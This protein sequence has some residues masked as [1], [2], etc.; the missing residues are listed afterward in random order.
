MEKKVYL[1]SSP[2]V[3]QLKVPVKPEISKGKPSTRKYRTF[4]TEKQCEECGC[5]FTAK[6]S[7][8]R[9]CSLR[10]TQ[11]NYYQRN[12]IKKKG[13][14]SVPQK[15]K[16]SIQHDPEI[17]T[18]KQFATKIGVCKQTVYSM[19][20][21]GQVHIIRFSK[22]LSYISWTEFVTS[23]SENTRFKPMNKETDK[24][25]PSVPILKSDQTRTNVQFPQR[26]IPESSTA[27]L[28]ALTASKR[29]GLTIR[30][31]YTYSTKNKILKKKVNGK[32]LYS[33]ND[34][35]FKRKFNL[36]IPQDFITVEEAQQKYNMSLEKIYKVIKIFHLTYI[37]K[38]RKIYI[39]DREFAKTLSP[40]SSA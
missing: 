29:Y 28:D 15:D 18:V 21:R 2:P 22:H 36:T 10:C 35:D 19:A 40:R 33:Q 3:H 32:I 24:V 9:F 31:F 25:I 8:T 23:F 38:M 30:S 1:N 26:A 16:V 11:K 17:L 13:Q 12:K 39:S 14:K 5:K 6:T 34:L 4:T 7:V 37:I 27:W 20:A